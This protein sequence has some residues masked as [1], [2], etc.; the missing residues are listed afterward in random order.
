[1]RLR[2]YLS[3]LSKVEKL[4]LSIRNNRV[5][6]PRGLFSWTSIKRCANKYYLLK[7]VLHKA[8]ASSL[9]ESGSNFRVCTSAWIPENYLMP[10]SSLMRSSLWISIYNDI[11]RHGLLL[12]SRSDRTLNYAREHIG[13]SPY[14][15]CLL[16]EEFIDSDA[17]TFRRTVYVTY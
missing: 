7:Y 3:I 15:T 16:D 13:G 10:G 6:F 5:P 14:T 17:S 12:A 9:K 2:N 1:M 4:K 8:V 11:D